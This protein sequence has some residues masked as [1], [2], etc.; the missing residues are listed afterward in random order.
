MCGSKLPCLHSWIWDAPIISPLE[1]QTLWVCFSPLHQMPV[2]CAMLCFSPS[3]SFPLFPPRS[4]ALACDCQA[5]SLPPP[6]RSLR[7]PLLLPNLVPMSFSVTGPHY[8]P[9][10]EVGSLSPHHSSMSS[11]VRPLFGTPS[12]IRLHSDSVLICI[13]TLG[14]RLFLPPSLL[15]LPLLSSASP[16]YPLCCHPCGPLCPPCLPC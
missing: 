7:S 10:P 8:L 13:T 15:G 9:F 2:P 11:L 1:S 6:S 12:L 5:I 14:A 4:L 16:P 3:S